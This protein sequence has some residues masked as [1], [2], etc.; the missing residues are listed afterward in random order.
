MGNLWNVLF[1]MAQVPTTTSTVGGGADSGFNSS[2]MPWYIMPAL[3]I[4]GGVLAFKY[5]EKILGLKG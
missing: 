4:I 1:P 2:K 3:I 5:G